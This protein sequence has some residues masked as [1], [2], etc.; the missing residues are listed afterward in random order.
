[1]QPTPK[2]LRAIE[3]MEGFSNWGLKKHLVE[4]H[5]LIDT[6]LYLNEGLREAKTEIHYWQKYSETL[7][8]KIC[9]HGFSVHQILSG[10]TLKSDYYPKELNDKLIIDSASAKVILR[11]QLEAYL[12]YRNI[13][14]NPKTN[15]E[16]ELRY[17]TWICAGLYQ[18]QNFP[19]NTKFAQIQKEKDKKEIEDIKVKIKTFKTFQA[20]SEKQKKTLLS[21]G[22]HKFFNHWAT[23]LQESGYNEK[24]A[25]SVSYTHWSSYSHSEGISAIQLHQNSLLYNDNDPHAISDLHTS[26]LIICKLISI[27]KNSFKSAEIKYN[28]LP[29]MLKFDIN[30]YIDLSKRAVF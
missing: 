2:D 8:F 20:L 30:F 23:I 29:E 1:M 21:V 4:Y 24:H 12:M 14:V 18:R 13:Y 28:T 9:F 16:K 3:L 22:T 5:K 11:S 6:L 17:L 27:L 15:E 26:K 7:L 25:F 19:S 10:L